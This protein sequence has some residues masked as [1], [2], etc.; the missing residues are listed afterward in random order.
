MDKK[1]VHK[2]V[3][4]ACGFIENHDFSCKMGGC[5]IVLAMYVY[6]LV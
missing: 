4:T 3:K 6:V 1:Y 5:D 2:S